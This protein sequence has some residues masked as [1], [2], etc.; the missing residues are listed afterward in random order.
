[1]FTGAAEGADAAE[2]IGLGGGTTIVVLLV[3]L[4]EVPGGLIL[5]LYE[6]YEKYRPTAK[7]I[8]NINAKIQ[9]ADLLLLL[10][11]YI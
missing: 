3:V 2:G 1:M 7:I 9:N 11:L 8:I 5:E 6:L 10:L 4:F